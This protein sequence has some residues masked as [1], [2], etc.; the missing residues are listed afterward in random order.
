METK[1][2]DVLVIDG[3]E[4]ERIETCGF[5]AR[6]G[7]VVEAARGN[8]EA[9]SLLTGRRF[10]LILVA[11]DRV[12]ASAVDLTRLVRIRGRNVTTPIVLMAYDQEG[13]VVRQSLQAGANDVVGRPASPAVL[14]RLFGYW[15][16]RELPADGHEGKRGAAVQEIQQEERS[17]GQGKGHA[18]AFRQKPEEVCV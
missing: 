2:R 9:L 7:V 1:L 15:L 13:A 17:G 10:D 12:G 16:D 14:T 6:F 8:S 18:A 4:R 5:L 11:V 3:D